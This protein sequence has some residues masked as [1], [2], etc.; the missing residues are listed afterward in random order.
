[1]IRLS[2]PLPAA[3]AGEGLLPRERK[4]LLRPQRVRNR[5]DWYLQLLHCRH[6]VVLVLR[7]CEFSAVCN[8]CFRSLP[9]GVLGPQ[10][11]L[12]LVWASSNELLLTC[13]IVH[14][15]LAETHRPVHLGINAGKGTTNTHSART[16]WSTHGRCNLDA[17][18]T[19]ATKTKRD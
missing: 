8:T 19:I 18:F 9:L 15:N 3:G 14:P 12:G 16:L 5:P 7:C 11:P 4:A 6:A 2:W 1:M 13:N 10:G 17:H